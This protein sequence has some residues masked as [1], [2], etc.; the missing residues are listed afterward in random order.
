VDS[1]RQAIEKRD[2]V[3][4][5]VR[6]A[7]AGEV[8]VYSSDIEVSPP[9]KRQI[10]VFF[11]FPSDHLV[12][13]AESMEQMEKVVSKLKQNEKAN[14]IPERWKA[15]GAAIDLE[16]PIVLLRKLRGPVCALKYDRAKPEK[17]EPRNVDIDSFALAAPSGD[18]L[19]FQLRCITPAPD[20]A[21]FFFYG[22][23]FTGGFPPVYWQWKRAVDTR[24]FTAEMTFNAEGKNH[25]LSLV[26]IT[27]FGVPI[28]I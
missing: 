23:T 25:H 6:V 13:R 12:V 5:S 18:A 24:G 10:T 27:L 3:V 28:G 9:S 19:R 8:S 4:G 1:L 7:Q 22:G 15:A 20:D 21:Q 2:G 11:A 16:A 26:L 14:E 17:I